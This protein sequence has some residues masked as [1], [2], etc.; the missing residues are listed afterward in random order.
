MSVNKFATVKNT[1]TGEVIAEMIGPPNAHTS[2]DAISEG[3]YAL[4]ETIIRGLQP[5]RDG[6]GLGGRFGYGANFE[7]DV[8][9]MHPFCWREEDNCL[10]CGGSGCQVEVS[11][12]RHRSGCYQ[13]RLQVLRKKFGEQAEWTEEKYFH[14][15]YGSPNQKKYEIAK[16]GLCVEMGQDFKFGNET[17]CTCGVID[18]RKARYDACECDWHVGRGLFRFGAATEAP[19]FWHKPSGLQV[20]WYKWIGRDMEL[21]N[22]RL[23]GK[24]WHRIMLECFQ[25]LPK[26]A[27]TKAFE[28]SDADAKR[29]ADPDYQRQQQ[30]RFDAMM[31]AL[32]DVHNQCETEGHDTKS[33]H[34]KRCGL[35]TD[36]EAH[37]SDMH[38]EP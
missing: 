16:R 12:E 38:A 35:V 33:G 15:P 4:S 34:C 32:D 21:S 6:G 8:F 10:W 30:E 3:L 2:G 5:D 26:E 17:H 11:D 9:M 18:E 1:E 36:F 31:R 24:E 13:E 14:V 29:D 37:I 22:E 23:S 28:A 27:R 25:S 19:H 20:R 7:N